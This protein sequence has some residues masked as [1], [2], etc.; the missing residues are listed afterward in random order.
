MGGTPS[1]VQIT[2]LLSSLS[3][4]RSLRLSLNLQLRATLPYYYHNS[5]SPSWCNSSPITAGESSPFHLL[6]SS[7]SHS[8]TTIVAFKNSQTSFIFFFYHQ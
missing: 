4:S 6:D 2:L 7:H 8:S 1:D 5:F 3:L